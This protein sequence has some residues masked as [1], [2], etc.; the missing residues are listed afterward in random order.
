MAMT[1]SRN[2][3]GRAARGRRHRQ[4][5]RAA[6][7]DFDRTSR[8]THTV[9][10]A[11]GHRRG[12]GLEPGKQDEG[13]APDLGSTRRVTPFASTRQHFRQLT[14]K[15]W[16]RFGTNAELAVGRPCMEVHR[17]APR[18]RS[19]THPHLVN[20]SQVRSQRGSHTAPSTASF[21]SSVSRSRVVAT[22]EARTVAM[23]SSLEC[24]TPST[25]TRS[26][27][28]SA[29]APERAARRS[30]YAARRH[31]WE[32]QVAGRPVFRRGTGAPQ[33][34]HTPATS[35]RR[36]SGSPITRPGGRAP[37]VTVLAAPRASGRRARGEARRGRHGS[38]ARPCSR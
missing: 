2:P 35:S 9:R 25:R 5:A 4:E 23:H 34:G 7:G 11:H 28:S 29:T 37:S 27:N 16:S 6:Q 3:G 14:Q 17:R 19:M 10:R 13:V 32:H 21:R 30:S 31:V 12:L 26:T 36:C 22:G 20:A 38:R 15:R 24:C 18:A 8:S 1:A 33:R